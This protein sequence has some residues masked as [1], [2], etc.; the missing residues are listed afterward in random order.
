[1]AELPNSRIFVATPL[2]NSDGGGRGQINHLAFAK[3]FQNLTFLWVFLYN[4]TNL[5]SNLSLIS[6]VLQNLRKCVLESEE[7]TRK[8][9]WNAHRKFW[10]VFWAQNHEPTLTDTNGRI[11]KFEPPSD[12]PGSEVSSPL[13]IHI[14]RTK[15]TR[16]NGTL[17]LEIRTKNGHK[18]RWRS[19]VG[20]F[21]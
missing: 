6:S 12:A 5:F 1:M 18:I 2:F 15:D 11:Q 17:F 3:V 19:H 10:L 7:N 16:A 14:K 9:T 8:I 20:L 13:W 4:F 21:L